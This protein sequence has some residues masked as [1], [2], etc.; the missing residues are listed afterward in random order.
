MRKYTLN[1]RGRLIF[2]D[3]PWYVGHAA[4]ITYFI[5]TRW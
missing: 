2:I 5:I 3:I 1:R 4:M